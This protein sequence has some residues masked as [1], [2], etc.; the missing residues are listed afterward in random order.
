MG[1]A[2]LSL[3]VHLIQSG[4]FSDKKILLIDKESKIQNDRTWC[5]WENENGL[6][7]N[8][9]YKSWEKVWIKSMEMEKLLLLNPYQYKLI[10]GKDFYDYCIQLIQKQTNFSII[11]SNVFELQNEGQ[12][13]MVKTQDG[14]FTTDYVFNSI[15]FQK[16]VL[17]AKEIYLQ[18][19]FKGWVI[20]TPEAVFN[21]DEATLMD[22][23]VHQDKGTAF[24]YI[25]P[26]SERR[27]LVEFTLF[28]KNLLAPVE[29]DEALKNYIHQYLTKGSYKIAE[30][31][32]GIIPMTN[33]AFVPVQGRIIHM[34]IVGGQ[35]KASSG[36]TFQFIQKHSARL[37]RSL[38]KKKN[39]FITRPTGY[40]RFH[41]YD[42]VLLYILEKGN[43]SGAKIFP[44]LFK[45]NKPRQVLRFLDN[46]SSVTD[47]VKI[48]SL[49]PMLPF[50]KAAWKQRK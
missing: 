37:V 22:F 40:R 41:F 17:S 33:H 14:I 27:A 44:R 8:I 11:Y 4:K 35:T 10:R 12:L 46:E 50:I 39:P 7:Q 3:A 47:E 16:P 24:V 18:Q 19:H 5:F 9:V 23:N 32:T 2:G 1:C 48:L 21:P 34:G 29:Y 43:L 6:F 36:Y 45:K 30:E 28:S 13:V 25:M 20:E 42:S 31:E 38:I 49:L 15:L 26:F